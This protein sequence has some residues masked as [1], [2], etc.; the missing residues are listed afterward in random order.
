MGLLPMFSYPRQTLKRKLFGYMLLLVLLLL[1]TLMA[2]LFLFGRFHSTD[3]DAYD[4]LDIQ[5]D[6]F[7]KDITTYFDHLAAS[8][9]RL[10]EQMS[11][12][13]ESHLADQ[14]LSMAELTDH[15][16][17][18]TALQEAMIAPLQLK[19]LQESCS[20]VFVMLD[21]TVNSS[22]SRSETSRTGLYLQIN[23]YDAYGQDI[24]LYRGQADL[25]KRHGMMPHRKW[26]LEFDTARISDYS[27]FRS[28]AD[29]PIDQSY[30]LT[31]IQPL[32]GTSE[33]VLLLVV[34]MTGTDGTYYG[35]CGFEVSAS[36]FMT[37]HAQS[38]KISHLTCLLTPEQG[39][40]LDTTIGLSCGSAEGYYRI[41]SG[42]LTAEDHD[43][44]LTTITGDTIP[45]LG[46]T[47][48]VAL[49]PNNGDF[50]LAVMM[51]KDDYDAAT[52]KNTM[53][54]ILLW[55]LVLFFAI[56]CCLFFS[57]RFL[58]PILK[59]LEQLKTTERTHSNIPEIDDLFAFLSE[60]DRAHEQALRT[61]S[62]E[63][64]QAQMDYEKAQTEIS[65][66]SYRMKQEVD[67]DEYQYFL[68]GLQDLTPT[69]RKIFNLYFDGK[70]AKEILEILQIKENTLKFHNKGIY[71]K[72]GVNSRKQ[73]LQYAALMKQA[74]N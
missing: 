62:E 14:G 61:L 42:I 18:I 55:L 45:Y 1:L 34:P 22:L 41:P 5:M 33:Q 26:K 44:K 20:G 4:T 9:I 51:L 38:T 46:I 60:Q 39:S 63:K 47:R 49:T 68:Q 72:L 36:F 29:L 12:L 23:G 53:Q 64:Q 70:S 54:N 31:E 74:A 32:P 56:N 48:T 17:A 6:V 24:L 59:A 15:G 69:E 11:A 8:G 43:G 73:L 67:P 27:Y 25:A 57:R 7:E 40:I 50:S 13:V 16:D 30:C 21:A 19:L 71:S 3:Q 35:L 66:L 58:T 10:S 2:G 28:L 52:Q 65:R 37:Y